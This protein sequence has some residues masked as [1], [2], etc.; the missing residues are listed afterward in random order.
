MVPSSSTVM[1][2]Q[3]FVGVHIFPQCGKLQTIGN[4]SEFKISPLAACRRIQGTSRNPRG[5]RCRIT[6]SKRRRV[7]RR[8]RPRRC[9][10]TFHNPGTCLSFL[11]SPAPFRSPRRLAGS[12]LR[13]PARAA[14]HVYPELRKLQLGRFHWFLSFPCGLVL[15]GGLDAPV[16]YRVRPRFFI[17]RS[18]P[19]RCC[20]CR[21]ALRAGYIRHSLNKTSWPAR[22]CRWD[23][24]HKLRAELGSGHRPAIENHHSLTFPNSCRA[25]NA[26]PAGV[27]LPGPT[28]RSAAGA[29]RRISTLLPLKTFPQ[30]IRQRL[31][32]A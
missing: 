25:S 28:L 27:G 21:S 6:G 11:R 7:H 23:V 18:G 10:A 30:G 9:R 5:S 14:L 13:A 22:L 12:G 4:M 20:G 24:R 15:S 31:A 3:L 29:G 17:F 2:R 1:A 8:S 16:A 26:S 19:H 32:L